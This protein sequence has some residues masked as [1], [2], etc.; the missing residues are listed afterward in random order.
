MYV[1]CTSEPSRLLYLPF[2]LCTIDYS[3]VKQVHVNLPRLYKNTT[4]YS[5]EVIR[6]IRGLHPQ[7]KVYRPSRDMG[8]ATKVLFTLDRLRHAYKHRPQSPI[9]ISIDDDVAYHT[10]LFAVLGHYVAKKGGV[11]AS[12][13]FDMDTYQEL[14]SIQWPAGRSGKHDVDIVE[15]FSGV[16]YPAKKVNTRLIKKYARQSVHCKLS[17]DLTISFALRQSGLATR[18]IPERPLKRRHLSYAGWVQPLQYGEDVGL[19]VKVP[20]AGF[21][22]YNT[23]KYH[24]CWHK[25]LIHHA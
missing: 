18:L 8:P 5:E 23:F 2:V 7:I 3:R 16:A 12:W 13:G 17:D 10:D 24:D 22:T 1:S 9:C 6:V 11:W 20:P 21:S 19:H 15:G 25:H 4:P 14:S